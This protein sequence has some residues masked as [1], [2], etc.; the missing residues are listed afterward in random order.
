MTAGRI[1]ALS[2]ML[3]GGATLFW[4]FRI[5]ELGLGQNQD[6]GPRMFPLL[7]SGV[8][9]LGGMYDFICSFACNQAAEGNPNDEAREDGPNMTRDG[10]RNFGFV[11]VSLLI[12]VAA[13]GF[14]G[15]SI[16]TFVFAVGMMVKLGV[17]PRLALLA[18]VALIAGVQIL[19]VQLFK[20]QLP[21][22]VLGV[23]F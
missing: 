18:S 20:V 14:L 2:L 23:A 7:L 17:R 1:A 16:S 11:L 5:E 15:F 22:G 3:L 12:Y 4:S 9:V 13:I 6:P 21:A 19:F 10:L 8:L